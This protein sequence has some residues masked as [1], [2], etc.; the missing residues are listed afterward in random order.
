MLVVIDYNGDIYLFFLGTP[1]QLHQ[2][3]VVVGVCE[4]TGLSHPRL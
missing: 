3:R 1:R 2:E 4:K